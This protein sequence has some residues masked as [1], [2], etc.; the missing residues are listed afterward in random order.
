MKDSLYSL[1]DSNENAKYFEEAA[2]QVFVCEGKCTIEI[3]KAFVDKRAH[4][5]RSK[6]SRIWQVASTYRQFNKK[7]LQHWLYRKQ[8][9][10]QE[11]LI[12][13]QH[14]RHCVG[15]QDG[16]KYFCLQDGFYRDSNLQTQHKLSFI[17]S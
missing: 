7:S 4:E 1:T 3:F 11:K 16:K 13:P 6:H 14:H 12:A 9:K 10:F 5:K 15:F 17:V 2:Q 8:K